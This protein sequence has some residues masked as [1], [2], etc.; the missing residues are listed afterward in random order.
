MRRLKWFLL[1][2]F[3]AFQSNANEPTWGGFKICY[4]STDI[5]KILP[6][7]SDRA[8]QFGGFQLAID[9]FNQRSPSKARLEVYPGVLLPTQ[10]DRGIQ[11][12]DELGCHVI[13][14][15]VTSKDALLAG[16]ELQRR[17]IVGFS[18]T[19]TVDE[20]DQFFPYVLSASSSQLS[21]VKAM[22]AFLEN[23]SFQKIFFI[24]QPTD[25]YSVFFAQ[26][27]KKK[28]GSKAQILSLNFSNEIPENK[29]SMLEG[30]KSGV[31]IYTTYPLASF[32]SL[33]QLDRLLPRVP[34]SQFQIFGTHSWM[35]TQT[36]QA[37]KQLI[38]RLPEIHVFNP[39]DTQKK[40]PAF[41]Q[42]QSH[43]QKQY[44]KQP[45]HDSAYDFDVTNLILKCSSG[46]S[47]APSSSSSVVLMRQALKSCLARPQRFEGVTGL[48]NFTGQSAHPIRVEHL[49]QLS[50]EGMT[51]H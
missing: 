4:V 41:L 50:L 11:W 51:P 46:F 2:F 35:E 37:H 30:L 19:A 45:D 44:Q 31:F 3:L 6:R 15:L 7:A 8:S 29:R 14:G 20:L 47:T 25:V 48:Y 22:S 43:Y 27:L 24:T 42:F 18:S 16:K 26:K 13:V 32:P 49:V 28:I 39:W 34:R 23:K 5:G 17:K 38:A 36:F 21:W 12:A 40:T 10:V 33:N 9:L 1:G